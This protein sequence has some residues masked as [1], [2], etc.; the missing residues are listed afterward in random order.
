MEYLLLLLSGLIGLLVFAPVIVITVFVGL[1][2]WF[3]LFD[4]VLGDK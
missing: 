2:S 4:I 3:F 1:F